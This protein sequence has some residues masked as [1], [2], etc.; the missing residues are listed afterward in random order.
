MLTAKIEGNELV[1][2]ITV[3]DRP[4]PSSSGKTMI[5]A[6]SHGQITTDCVVNG[7][8]LVIGMNAY[9]PVNKGT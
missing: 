6:S 7:K 9:I 5:I 2:R 3:N 4:E 1:I 8:N